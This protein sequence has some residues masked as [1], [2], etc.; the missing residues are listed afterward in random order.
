MLN[1]FLW[2]L[3][4]ILAIKFLSVAYTHALRQDKQEML[5]GIQGMG[6]AA[7][8][9]LNV[10]AMCMLLGCAGL[11]LPAAFESLTWLTPLTAAGLAVLMLASI[12][13]HSV[14]REKSN[15]WVSLVLFVLSAS[16]AYG[17]WLLLP[18]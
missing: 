2:V 9:A 14:C 1:T 10:I 6:A 3:Q 8:P 17:R 5:Q 13:F 15:A 11:V 16:V 12:L 18:P 7:R 4:I